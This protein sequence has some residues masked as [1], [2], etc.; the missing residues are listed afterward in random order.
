MRIMYRIAKRLPVLFAAGISTYGFAAMADVASSNILT[1]VTDQFHTQTATWGNVITG[2]ATRLFWALGTISLV[3]TGS[4]LIF[5]KADIGEFFAEFIRFILFFGFY[6]WLLQNAPAIGT[7]IINSM[8]AIGANASQT[9]ASNPSAVMDIGF[10]IFHKVMEQ[11]TIGEPVDSIIGALLAGIILVCIA[12]IAAN[13]TIMLCSAW[14]LL[15][16]GIFFLGFG[17]SRWTSD[18]AINYYK[19][20]LS[21]AAS[22]MAMILM[23]GIAQSIITN[24][25]NQMSTGINVN[26]I[27]TIMVVAII[28][29]LLIHRIPGLI[30]GILT[31]G[32]IGNTGIGSMGAGTAMGAMGVAAAAAGMGGAVAASAARNIATGGAT[33]VAVMQAAGAM[34]AEGWSSNSNSTRTSGGLAEAMGNGNSAMA[35]MSKDT[36]SKSAGR[37]SQGSMPNSISA[38]HENNSDDSDDEIT[39]FVHK[40]A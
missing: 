17:G 38:A 16:G 3:W 33:V 34:M 27:A 28:L 2:Y 14:V 15:Y 5:K 9:E 32:T 13:M 40:N 19:T 6:L 39:A 7:S 25:Y 26:E 4:G 35:P 8:V 22:L 30:S 20:I 31:G 21:V 36:G 18:I 24:Y 11:T 10:N 23:V 29:L 1:N 12:L 37:S